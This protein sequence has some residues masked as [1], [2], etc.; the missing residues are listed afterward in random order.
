MGSLAEEIRMAF[1]LL[2]DLLAFFYATSGREKPS[3]PADGSSCPEC[4]AELEEKE[5]G[6]GMRCPNCGEQSD[7]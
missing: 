4:G 5:D 1:D 7:C 2:E 3:T 6:S